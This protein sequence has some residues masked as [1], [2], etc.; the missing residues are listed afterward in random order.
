MPTQW[1]CDMFI[2]MLQTSISIPGCN[3][4][5]PIG[6]YT[7]KSR[8]N[9]IIIDANTPLT[10]AIDYFTILWPHPRIESCMQVY[11]Q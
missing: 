3:Q 8:V 7:R 1:P 11:C 5:E 10:I 6:W 4:G 2:I 9:N